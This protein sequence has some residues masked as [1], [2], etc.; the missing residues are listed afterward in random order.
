MQTLLSPN[1]LHKCAQMKMCLEPLQP[2]YGTT[3]SR[4]SHVRS[5]VSLF[6]SLFWVLA[7]E[8]PGLCSGLFLIDEHAQMSAPM[9]ESRQALG[10]NM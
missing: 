10:P 6:M 3:L 9:M 5:K 8:L 7:F 1:M 2:T 4:V